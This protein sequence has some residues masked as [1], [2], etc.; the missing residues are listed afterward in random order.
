VEESTID[1]T[2]RKV[3][4]GA[5]IF[6]FGTVF[7]LLIG[8]VTRVIVVRYL[9]KPDYGVLTLALTIFGIVQAVA[10]FGIP[11]A[12]VRQFSY[13]SGKGDEER[14]RATVKIALYLI[15]ALG[16]IWSVLLFLFS[17]FLAETFRMPD[18]SWVLRLISF[19]IPFALLNGYLVSL[20]Q[21]F[22]NAKAKVIF[23]DFLLGFFR[24]LFVVLV[25]LAGLSFF[26]VVLAYVAIP[27]I[28]AFVLFFL[29]SLKDLSKFKEV[30]RFKYVK[31]L[32]S[33]S[34]PLALQSI[35]GMI[36]TWID[37]LMLGY[38]LTAKDVAVYGAA[39]PI[40][41]TLT[42]VL[43]AVNFLYLPLVSQL[44]GKNKMKE[45]KRTYAIITKWITAIT[46][47]IFLVTFLF[48]RGVIWV[49]YGARYLDASPVL[50]ILALTFFLH[51]AFG[52]NGITLVIFGENKFVTLATTIAALIN[53]ILNILLIPLFGVTG[54]AVATLVTYSISNAAYNVKLL[55]K[56]SIHPFTKNYLKPIVICIPIAIVISRYFSRVGLF[57]L[58]LL[59]LLFLVIYIIALIFTRSFDWED[60]SL[61]LILEQR[62]GLDL[63]WIKRVLKRFII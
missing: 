36:I 35:L 4:K 55:I 17:G 53:V 48:S 57:D 41:N 19:S 43:G 20:Y 23:N 24:F 56:Y 12:M 29:Y 61:L 51:V 13:Y 28:L 21:A 40:A 63:G 34:A 1:T 25:I 18:L 5:G 26:G 60:I 10:S 52:P 46:L 27:P 2:L 33:F 44:F 62:L 38:F 11:L 7:S 58:V 50:S 45:I 22:E 39:K 8:L 49:L 15:I 32:L 31:E 14:A 42:V 59:F 54:A 30:L 16:L 47:P 37:V 9:S 3:A 6:L